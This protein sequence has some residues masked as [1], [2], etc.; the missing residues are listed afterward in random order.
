LI[1]GCRRQRAN[2]LGRQRR[3]GARRQQRCRR[4]R[5]FGWRVTPSPGFRRVQI[6]TG[7]KSRGRRLLA[8]AESS[9]RVCK[10]VPVPKRGSRSCSKNKG[11]NWAQRVCQPRT[12]HLGRSKR[13]QPR[14]SWP[15]VHTMGCKIRSA[16]ESRLDTGKLRVH[17]R[18]MTAGMP[19]CSSLR[20]NLERSSER[21]G[22]P[23]KEAPQRHQ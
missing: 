18:K 12:A 2:S 19:V 3:L 5:S 21:G 17:Q 15:M 7:T 10:N 13:H 1:V 20:T 16:C 22:E 6:G 8:P 23:R 4:R 9:G 11:L 14:V